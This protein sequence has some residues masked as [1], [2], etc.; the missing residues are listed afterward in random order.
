LF[1]ALQS[2]RLWLLPRRTGSPNLL[3]LLRS[4]TQAGLLERLLLAPD[5]AYT[6][7]ELASALGVTDMS[8]RRELDRMRAAG[9]VERQ[10]VGRQG[11]FRADRGSPL[12]E[13]LRQLVERS[14]G[15]EALLRESLNDIPGVE[16]AGIFGSWA[17]GEV[18]AQSDVDL[19]V[20]GDF[21]YTDVVSRL[22]ELQERTG[23]EI[24]M[25]AMRRDELQEHLN[26]GSG[27]LSSILSSPMTMLVGDRQDL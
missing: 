10:R 24:S 18:D 5:A 25:V 21:D 20:I 4:A 17:R 7:S 23:R 16:A 26:E 12:Y 6:V 14:V 8:V 13:P 27:F 19:L 9:I 15:V 22:Q 11:L 1:V 2:V 3:P